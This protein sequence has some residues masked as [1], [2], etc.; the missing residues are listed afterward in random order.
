MTASG[1]AQGTKIL[2]VRKRILRVYYVISKRVI[3]NLKSQERR[4]SPRINPESVEIYLHIDKV[5]II[6]P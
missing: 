6:C 3:A 5:I 4:I 2:W 1:S